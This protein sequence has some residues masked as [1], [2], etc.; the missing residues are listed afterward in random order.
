[1]IAEYIRQNLPMD[2]YV[3]QSNEYVVTQY[4][5]RKCTFDQVLIRYHYLII[6]KSFA[7]VPGMDQEDL[8]QELAMKL[9][10]CCE[11]WDPNMGIIFST[12]FTEACKNHIKY[13]LRQQLDTNT[14]K[15][16]HV[17]IV[18]LDD[19]L[20]DNDGN[21]YTKNEP[22]EEFEEPISILMI[23]LPITEVEKKYLNL[24]LDGRT[25]AEISRILKVSR[26]R[27]SQIL[28]GIGVRLVEAGVEFF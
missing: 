23:G 27:V 13:I 18:S 21:E 9:V 8:Y 1:M 7:K 17:G 14:R 11:S 26:A 16:N 10:K 22:Y 12:Y 20:T 15:S 2:Q 5:R 6:K 4:K 28:R 24:V 3:G 25:N 19:I